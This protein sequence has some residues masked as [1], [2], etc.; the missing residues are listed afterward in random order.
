[1][2]LT[3]CDDDERRGEEWGSEWKTVKYTNSL[4]S[5]GRWRGR[6]YGNWVEE[7]RAK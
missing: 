3:T 6:P 1:M 5:L 2:N 7:E 4:N